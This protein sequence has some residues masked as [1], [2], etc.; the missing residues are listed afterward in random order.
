MIIEYKKER[1]EKKE[2]ENQ[3]RHDFQDKIKSLKLY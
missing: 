2:I 1:K 3:Q